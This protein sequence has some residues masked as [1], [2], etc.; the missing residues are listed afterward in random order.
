MFKKNYSIRLTQLY[1]L[2]FTSGKSK[3]ISQK[4]AQD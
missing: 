2:P 1:I 3:V 4:H